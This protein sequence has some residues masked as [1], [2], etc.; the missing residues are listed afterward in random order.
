MKIDFGGLYVRGRLLIG[1]QE[2]GSNSFLQT[3]N[4]ARIKE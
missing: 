2:R 4:I 1:G 3:K